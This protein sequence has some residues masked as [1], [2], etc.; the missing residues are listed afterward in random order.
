MQLFRQK[1]QLP[2]CIS[3]YFLIPSMA[4]HYLVV[5]LAARTFK[6]ALVPSCVPSHSFSAL[7]R[8]QLFLSL[9]VTPLCIHFS[10]SLGFGICHILN[11]APAV[12]PVANPVFFIVLKRKSGINFYQCSTNTGVFFCRAWKIALQDA[13]TNTVSVLP[14]LTESTHQCYV[15]SRSLLLK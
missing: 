6:T 11:S 2:W 9:G 12:P 1:I 4:A 13:R 5:V 3:S 10:V 7:Q 8:K 14:I 15:Q